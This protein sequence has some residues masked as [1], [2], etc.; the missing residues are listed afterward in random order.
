MST[1]N[2]DAMLA[3]LVV[4]AQELDANDMLS[5]ECNTII[6]ILSAVT[7]A[8]DS[9]LSNQ[10]RELVANTYLGFEFDLTE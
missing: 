8:P 3:G 5:R 7:Y 4:A 2:P 6:S 1:I 10:I 9:D